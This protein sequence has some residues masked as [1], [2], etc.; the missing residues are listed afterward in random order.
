MIPDEIC[1]KYLGATQADYGDDLENF[2][3]CFLH[4]TDHIPNKITESLVLTLHEATALNF[5]ANFITWLRTSYSEYA[6]IISY[7]EIARQELAR[8]QEEN[9]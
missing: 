6:D 1:L 2:Y 9:E 8:I 4:E 7:R 5:I 3:Q